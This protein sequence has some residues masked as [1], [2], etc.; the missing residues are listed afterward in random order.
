MLVG[1]HW[2]QCLLSTSSFTALYTVQLHTSSDRL[3]CAHRASS[4]TSKLSTEKNK[5]SGSMR[6]PI[7]RLY[8]LSSLFSIWRLSSDNA[9]F[10][11]RTKIVCL[12]TTLS[13]DYIVH[14]VRYYMTAIN[15]FFLYFQRLCR[16]FSITR[17]WY[18]FMLF[19]FLFACYCFNISDSLQNVF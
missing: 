19:V 4:Y 7:W 3:I 14:D 18:A 1:A 12:V 9:G 8:V 2:C 17:L 13:R 15:L 11:A 5:L 6:S 16:F 10:R